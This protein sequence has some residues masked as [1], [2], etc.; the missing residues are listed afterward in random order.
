MRLQPGEPGSD[1]LPNPA[2]KEE[3]TQPAGR[4]A[5]GPLAL[6]RLGGGR[7]PEAGAAERSDQG[8]S[9]NDTRS[10]AVSNIEAISFSLGGCAE[11]VR[12]LAP[13]TKRPSPA[14]SERVATGSPESSGGT[15]SPCCPRRRETVRPADRRWPLGTW[16][17]P[18]MIECPQPHALARPEVG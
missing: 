1:G 7:E 3:R 18:R 11:G 10:V 4:V 13:E 12:L 9:Q 16:L 6:Q 5:V 2:L 8:I 17:L 15:G 14:R